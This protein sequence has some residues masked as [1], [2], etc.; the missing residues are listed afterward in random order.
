MFSGES[1]KTTLKR[2]WRTIKAARSKLGATIPPVRVE[3]KVPALSA[4]EEIQRIVAAI[5]EYKLNVLIFDP[6]YL[7]L[8][9]GNRKVEPGN[10]FA[11]GELLTG[12]VEACVAEG[13][14]PVFRA[15][16]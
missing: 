6:L 9:R 7:G 8:L 3:Y 2:R 4:P 14:T 10:V 13:C 15:P 1:G 5:R 11:M 12:I 16:R